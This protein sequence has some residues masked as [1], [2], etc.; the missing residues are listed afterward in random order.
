MASV[1]IHLQTRR[2]ILLHCVTTLPPPP[3][4]FS[5]HRADLCWP[6]T[7]HRNE[8]KKTWFRQEEHAWSW[9]PSDGLSY[10]PFSSKPKISKWFLNIIRRPYVRTWFLVVLVFRNTWKTFGDS[11]MTVVKFHR[12]A[13]V[14]CMKQKWTENRQ[15]SFLQGCSTQQRWLET[16]NTG[17]L[18]HNTLIKEINLF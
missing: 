1:E 15:I 17:H 11:S 13:T 5:L 4:C 7:C 9:S 14:S 10:V 2:W 8:I 12:G 18:R 16:I 3:S 6:W